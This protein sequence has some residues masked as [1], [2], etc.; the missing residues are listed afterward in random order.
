MDSFTDQA[1]AGNP[2]GVVRLDDR[3]RYPADE[4]CAAVA[5]ELNLSET[6]FVGPTD[7]PGA[8]FRLRWF[9]PTIEVDLCGHATL[10]AAR[11][12]FEDGVPSPVRFATRSGVLTIEAAADGELVMDFPAQPP[13][14]IEPPA[15]LTAALG[16]E[17]LWVGAG[18]EDYLVELADAATVRSLTPD[19]AAIGRYPVRGV[20]VTAPADDTDGIDFVSRFFCPA[21]GIP[22]DPVTGSTHTL[23]GPYWA[24]K[25]GRDQVIGWQASRRGGRIGVAVVG[26]RV[27]LTGQAVV[28]M[29]GRFT[30]PAAAPA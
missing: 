13:T 25:L 4:W 6:A 21:V 22:E 23:L 27:R 17:P 7:E 16:V 12:L 26:D 9:T 15:D 11:C 1:F 10:A 30:E 28:V 29:D 24:G 20:I 14:P 5:A 8:D 3:D 18:G 2:A 19:V